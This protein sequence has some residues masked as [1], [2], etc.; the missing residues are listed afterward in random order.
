MVQTIPLDASQTWRFTPPALAEHVNAPAFLFK[1]ATRRD[2]ERFEQ[3]LI[4]EGLRSYGRDALRAE[5]IRAMEALYDAETFAR[6]SARLRAYWDAADGYE[7]EVKDLLAADPNAVISDFAHEDSAAVNKL[8]RD[9][10]DEWRPLREMAAANYRFGENLP[11]CML[12]ITVLRWEGIETSLC[13]AGGIIDLDSLASMRAELTDRFGDAGEL[14]W[15]QLSAEAMSSLHL[16]PDTEKNS[17]S[18][19]P[20]TPT[21]APTSK[22]GASKNG[23]S[24]ASEL[25]EPTPEN[26]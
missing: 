15:F 6:E 13:R 7:L 11:L 4:V 18:P 1:P 23:P 2:K 22:A 19:Q 9:I 12:A 21:P 25:S 10:A 26:S 5:T 3:L 17:A 24:P 14:A 20:S 8:G 16:L